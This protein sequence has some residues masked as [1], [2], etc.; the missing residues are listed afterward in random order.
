MSTEILYD[1][2]R[3]VG[4]LSDNLY[5]QIEGLDGEDISFT[6]KFIYNIEK[7]QNVKDECITA[8]SL[9]PSKTKT[10]RLQ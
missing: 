3:G 8:S 4:T 1:S 10:R 5:P 7:V 9:G 6:I 2:L